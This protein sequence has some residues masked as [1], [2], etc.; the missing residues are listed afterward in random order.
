[1]QSRWSD[2]DAQEFVNRY[3]KSGVNEDLNRFAFLVVLVHEFAHYA[4]F[5]K[6]R[7]HEPHGAEWKA[8]YKRLMRPLLS[9]EVFPA[10]VLRMGDLFLVV[11]S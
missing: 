6:Y 2:S 4:T 9:R 8:E 10:D 3:A 1:M 11:T 5:Q 7:R